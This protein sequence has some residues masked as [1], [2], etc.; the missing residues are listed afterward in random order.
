ML[1][2]VQNLPGAL[3]SFQSECQSTRS[4]AAVLGQRAD[5]LAGQAQQQVDGVAKAVTARRSRLAE[6]RAQL[7]GAAERQ[8]QALA[9]LTLT[10]QSTAQ[11]LA[12]QLDDFGQGCSALELQLGAAG[13]D[14]KK[15]AEHQR[16]V[17]HLGLD[18]IEGAWSRLEAALTEAEAAANQL[19]D[20]AV[21]ALGGEQ[22]QV[23]QL[24]EHLSQTRSNLV[25]DL[26]T[27]SADARA[28]E[29]RFTARMEQTLAVEICANADEIENSTGENLRVGVDQVS[30]QRIDR[31]IE[32]GVLYMQKQA[33]Q[34]QDLF[35]PPLHDLE[36]PVKRYARGTRL[37]PMMVAV[38]YYFQALQQEG[39]LAP[40][41]PLL[42]GNPD[43]V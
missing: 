15:A 37:K 4:E 39:L 6:S 3:A 30:Q 17:T 26:D 23:A 43:D 7:Q 19:R 8:Q 20:S 40:Y 10:Q 38:Y 2:Q 25:R 42:F 16:E 11:Q 28:A 27:F 18:A 1:D 9:A 31:Y 36:K 12:T 24:S 14:L 41:Y 34:S 13:S 5:A 29:Q 21:Q 22:R 35:D 32:Q 33:I